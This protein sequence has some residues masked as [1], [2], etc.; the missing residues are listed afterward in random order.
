MSSP[1][2]T[3]DSD[4][5]AQFAA[6]VADLRVLAEQ[7]LPASRED[8]GQYVTRVLSGQQ[9]A[10]QDCS[11]EYFTNTLPNGEPAY[12]DLTALAA[13]E[14]VAQDALMPAPTYLGAQRRA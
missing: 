7:L 13:R 1:G 6:P 5:V 14:G 12:D 3:V 11:T 4:T 8:T 10:V 9:Q 2:N